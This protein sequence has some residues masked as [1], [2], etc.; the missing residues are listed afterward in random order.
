MDYA[1]PQLL[2]T[3]LSRDLYASAS[4]FASLESVDDPGTLNDCGNGDACNG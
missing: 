2:T 1:T 3:Y 4:G